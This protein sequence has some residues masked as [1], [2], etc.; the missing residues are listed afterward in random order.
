MSWYAVDALEEAL[1]A[2]KAMLTPLDASQWL[3][4]ALVVFFLGS[5]AGSPSATGGGPTVGPS[6][7]RPGG[8]G[9]PD[10][11]VGQP[12]GGFVLPDWLADPLG[13]GGELMA[14]VSSDLLALAALAV[15]VALVVGLA[16]AFVGSVMEFVFVESLRRERVR[17]R[18]YGDQHLWQAVRLF[19]FR[20]V[21]GLVVTLPILG[22]VIAAVSVAT[23]S[24]TV[25]VGLLVVL[26]P[27][28]V[29]L[30]LVVAAIDTFTTSFVV[31]VM[32]R[33]N[34]GVLPA[35]RRFWPTLTG[36]WKQ[37][38]VYV[39]VR[40][41]LAVAAGLLASVVGSVVG[42]VIAAPL[43]VVGVLVLP[44]FGGP[45]AL[46]S[47]PVTLALA[48]AV[49][50]AYLAALTAAVAVAFVPIRTYLRY[51][52]LLVLGDTEPQFDLIPD[53]RREIRGWE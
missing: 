27:L 32:I 24:P 46:L 35:W 34:L 52:A 28:F 19:A 20:V 22:G 15:G 53:R 10:G 36:E 40:F 26:V 18:R 39:L 21:L 8:V 38:G 25:S 7:D 14:D 48:V 29:L 16:Y 4:L 1:D 6:M 9:G 44:A 33:T 51:H 12:D 37:Y 30:G 43:A 41:G 45:A 23:G 31:P 17:I 42:A 49:V 50:L 5:T 47:N 13:S 3:R 11:P 2:T